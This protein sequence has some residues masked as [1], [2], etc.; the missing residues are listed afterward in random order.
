MSVPNQPTIFVYTGNGVTTT[1]AYGFY[2]LSLDDIVVVV[3]DVVQTSGFTVNGVGSQSGGAVI[4]DT[5]PADGVSIQLL[6]EVAVERLT[7]Y[8]RNGDLRASTLNTD[9]DRLWMAL[10][11]NRRDKLS[12][13]RY[14]VF[15]NLDGELPGKGTRAG[16]LLGFDP[17]GLHMIYPVTA[18]IGAGDMRV[19]T[20]VAGVDF[21]PGASTQLTLSRAPGN[22]ANAEVFFDPLFQGPDQWSVAG[23]VLTF[24]TPIPVGVTKVFVRLGTTLSTLVPALDSV[25]DDELMWGSILERYV[26]STAELRTLNSRYARATVLGGGHYWRDASDTTSADD[27]GSVIVAADGG[28]WKLL[29]TRTVSPLEFGAKGDWNGTTG[30]DDSA[31]L[32]ACF[33]FAASKGYTVEGAG[34]FYRVLSDVTVTTGIVR[35]RN[36]RFA[37][38]SNYA[39]QAQISATVADIDVRHV[40]ADGGRGTY[41]TGNEPWKVFG[42]FN[43]YNSIEPTLRPLFSF[44]NYAAGASARVTVDDVHFANVH[45]VSALN[46]GTY[47]RVRLGRQVYKNCSNGSYAVYHSPDNGVTV[48]GGTQ[49]SDIVTIDIGLLPGSF[50]IDNVL[51]SFAA[52]TGLPQGSFN[53]LVSF[54]EYSATN[55]FNWNYGACAIT[56]DRNTVFNGSNISVKHTAANGVSNNPSG[57]I[58]NEACKNFNLTNAVVDIQDRD[59]RD[60][61]QDS[62]ALQLFVLDDQQVN[63]S[64]ITL[65][66]NKT[67]AKAR[68]AIRTSWFGSTLGCNINADNVVVDGL[69]AHADS[70]N[71]AISAGSVINGRFRISKLY[72]AS[73]HVNFDQPQVLELSQLQ[74]TGDIKVSTSGNP[75]ISGAVAI[76]SLRDSNVNNVTLAPTVNG[77]LAIENNETIAG[78]I[79][80]V[81]VGTGSICGNKNITGSVTYDTGNPTLG[82]MTLA[83]NTQ[84]LG[85]TTI[86]RAR[87]AMINGNHTTRRIEVKDV[88]LFNITGNTAKTDQPEPI[89]SINPVTPAN[90]LAGT[91]TGNNLLIR[92][93]TVGAGY[94]T[95]AGG[96]GPVIDDP[97]NNKV[98]TN[99]S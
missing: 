94:V 54:G 38:S 2:L 91:I 32:Q 68:R 33:T 26:D 58:W 15:E 46:I 88:Q 13:L 89:I 44:Q 75:G 55:Y 4:F 35:W 53:G 71:F 41:K 36:M 84:I 92:T 65:R 43:G 23:N 28:R 77:T 74:T 11:D 60:Y 87:S 97:S 72:V 16:G 18:S 56:A 45:A 69:Y 59:A 93:G 62:C 10:Q 81:C 5:A 48:D 49:V 85:V 79:T 76:V 64:N 70:V 30:T 39:S 37:F 21:T 27:N 86:T 14:P 98:T 99:W 1:F 29:T 80:A 63:L 17:S 57:A 22:P 42:S 52:T 19:D 83:N 90:V 78:N 12:S 25:G 95:V 67:S 8:Q 31:A 6:R 51:T 24:L 7:D 47:G 66:G 61:A 34:K 20:F 73:G 9:F 82:S 40:Y 3:N 96:T 50:L